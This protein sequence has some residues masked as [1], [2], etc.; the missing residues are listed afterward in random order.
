M[1][2]KAQR[3]IVDKT[4]EE[5]GK[6][7]YKDD[8]LNLRDSYIEL[9]KGLAVAYNYDKDKSQ[10]YKDNANKMI[11]QVEK[12]DRMGK[13]E[14]DEDTNEKILIPYKDDEKLYDKFRKENKALHRELE[15]EFSSMKTEVAF[16]RNIKESIKEFNNKPTEKSGSE[17][18]KNFIELEESRAFTK[19]D[20]QGQ[21]NLETGKEINKERFYNNYPEA[22]QELDKSVKTHLKNQENDKYKEKGREI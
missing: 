19:T 20:K 3:D 9:N 22:I 8:F 10:K 2:P 11:E 17:I 15:N 16:F 21:I 13:W 4:L 1:T 14:R 7:L 6:N 18:L 5:T 12:Q